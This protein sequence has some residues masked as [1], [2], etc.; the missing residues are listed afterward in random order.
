MT[1]IGSTGI[2]SGSTKYTF[3]GNTVHLDGNMQIDQQTLT[4][5]A[6][7]IWDVTN[8]SNAKFTFVSNSRTLSITNAVTGD[9]GVILVKQGT[10]TTYN[11]TL[12]ATSVIIG[13]GTYTTTTTSNGIDVLGVYYDGTNY[14]W[15][16]PNGATGEKGAQG[17]TGTNAG[18]TTYTTP[19]S[20]HV[21]VGGATSATIVGISNIN[22]DDSAANA[23]VYITGSLGVGTGVTLGN[24]QGLIKATNDIVAYATSDKRLKENIIQIPSA[25]DKVK[26]INGVYFD[27]ISLSEEEEKTIHGN[28]GHDIGVIAQEI[29]A[30]LPE[31]VTT[32]DNGYKAVK[33]EKIV[34]L[35]IEAI[36]EQQ[37][38]IDELKRKINE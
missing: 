4:D 29:E 5:A 6:P 38:E 11:L 34:A 23:R 12:P 16:I 8:G 24:T 13:G 36:K 9:T 31:L 30:I 20:G 19:G 7:V 35:L 32:R 28:K 10:G 3:D 17:T 2:I 15:S 25:I 22:Y 37:G 21:I 27:W 26:Q 33:Y 18:I 1:S 14:Y